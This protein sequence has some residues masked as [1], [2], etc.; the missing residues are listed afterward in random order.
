MKAFIVNIGCDCLFH[1]SE[2]VLI[3]S[4]YYEWA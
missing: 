2:I 4:N 1:K 3:D